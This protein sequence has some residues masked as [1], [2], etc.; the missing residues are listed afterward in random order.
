MA[1][2]DVI[3]T[4]PKSEMENAAREAANCIRDGGGEYFRKLPFVPHD[5]GPGSKVFYVEDG[6]VRGYAEVS[7]IA[8]GKFLCDTTGREWPKGIYAIMEAS[9]WKWIKP[10][11]MRGFQG[12]R[13]MKQPYKVI[14]DW[15]DPKP[16]TPGTLF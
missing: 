12:M 1:Q 2:V 11:A 6:F 16:A 15:K 5:F 4:T 8:T 14:G 9:S 13:L 3:V 7:R 10:I